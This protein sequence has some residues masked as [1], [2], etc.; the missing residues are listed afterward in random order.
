MNHVMDINRSS[1]T[2]AG[3]RKEQERQEQNGYASLFNLSPTLKE[4]VAPL[5]HKLMYF[6][7]RR[8]MLPGGGCNILTI[9]QA[10]LIST[11]KPF[12]FP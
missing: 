12:Q 4:E 3:K 10:L 8:Y 11:K 6:Y 9:V 2:S 7:F 1:E 5:V